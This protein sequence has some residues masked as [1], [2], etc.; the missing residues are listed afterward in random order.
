MTEA[1]LQDLLEKIARQTESLEELTSTLKNNNKANKAGASSSGSDYSE[2]Y[3]KLAKTLGESVSSAISKSF[4]TKSRTEKVASKATG[5]AYK[6]GATATDSMKAGD[7]AVKNFTKAV[8]KAAGDLTS[9][10][11]SL[12]SSFTKG[13]AGAASFADAAA[14]GGKFLLATFGAS[15]P[16]AV[17]AELALD[18]M[19]ASAKQADKLHAKNEELQKSG[20]NATDGLNSVNKMLG[21][22]GLSVDEA[23]KMLSLLSG[24]TQALLM[25]RTTVADGADALSKVF[26][27]MGESGLRKELK[28]LGVSYEEQ[29][30]SL[31]SNLSLQSRLGRSQQ[32]SVK[33]M[34]KSTADYLREQDALTRLTGA[35]RKEQE[36]ARERFMAQE[37]ARLKIEKLKREGK[38][39][40]AANLEQTNKQVTA[41]FGE[42]IAKQ[43]ATMSDGIITEQNKG[44]QI[45]TNGM[46]REIAMRKDL[47]PSQKAD[48]LRKAL[49]AAQGGGVE[50]QAAVGN[51]EKLTG[52]NYGKYMDAMEKSTDLEKRRNDV[53]QQQLK[54]SEGKGNV[55]EMAD[56]DEAN[57]KIKK[58]WMDFLQLVQGPLMK[59][60]SIVAKVVGALASAFSALFKAVEFIGDVIDKLSEAVDTILT[61]F[62]RLGDAIS[63][64]I[65]TIT[66]WIA[67][68]IDSIGNLFSSGGYTGDGGKYE[69]AGVVH[70]GE[71]VLNAET[72]RALGLNQLPGYASGGLVGNAGIKNITGGGGDLTDTNKTVHSFDEGLKKIMQNPALFG[73]GDNSLLGSRGVLSQLT[74]TFKNLLDSIDGT[75]GSLI[76]TITGWFSKSSAPT[77]TG[78][79][80]SGGSYSGGTGGT[81]GGYVIGGG[82]TGGGAATGN[83]PATQRG[84]KGGATQ[85]GPAAPAYEGLG[86]MSA[87]YESGSRGSEAIGYDKTGGTSYGKYQIASKTGTMDKFMSYLQETN[88]AAAA[89][90][91]AA[92]PAD[93]GKDGK[94]AQTW[95]DMAKSGELGTSE[96]DFIKKT[97]YDPA[98]AGIKDKGLSDMIGGNKALQDMMWSTSVQ[99]GGAGAS[100]IMNKVYKPGM[101][102]EDLTKAVY[103][104]R[105]TRFGSSDEK[106]RASVQSR[107]GKEQ[108][109]TLARLKDP[110]SNVAMAAPGMPVA[111]APG[112]PGAVDANGQ[113]IAG[114]TMPVATT[115]PTSTQVSDMMAGAQAQNQAVVAGG[116]GAATA[117][118]GATGANQETAQADPHQTQLLEN[119]V[120]LTRDQNATMNKILQSST[121]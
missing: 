59:G 61:P 105:G 79:N 116:V 54:L 57:L 87:K 84:M 64:L 40:E 60:F 97:H 69:P 45:L 29:R 111:A 66:N 95:Q 39:D 41:I 112:M 103:A 113:P 81:G 4:I 78:V 68:P 5:A 13:T 94:F 104:E 99:H 58:A 7:I 49:K 53:M 33:D 18:A 28:L 16:W 44:L 42:D 11:A 50:Q 118:A 98:M 114:P 71:Y 65:E 88:P 30:E 121:A 14:S 27:D 77:A 22:F 86:S 76:D 52:I 47:T 3:S 17:A 31:A 51:F 72:T 15:G 73:T 25:F 90:L 109:E 106:T 32:M 89:K 48:E 1:E 19:V 23:N 63:S 101:S 117:G 75:G 38:T 8:N 110:N 96:H 12:G 102:A 119:L 36:N 107:F 21:N 70:K 37:Q 2:S 120:S 24:N 83:I 82:T 35:T 46:A 92:G 10:F 91:Q 74:D 80:W 115:A 108:E 67:H 100:G 55:K 62:T 20:A 6:A 43:F 93:S 34:A 85:A 9:S 26:A 56:I